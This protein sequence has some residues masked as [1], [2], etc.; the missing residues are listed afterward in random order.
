MRE[1]LLRGY[2]YTEIYF[3]GPLVALLCYSAQIKLITPRNED[4]FLGPESGKESDGGRRLSWPVLLL[5]LAAVTSSSLSALC[6]CHLLALQAEVEE[7]R[8][9]SRRGEQRDVAHREVRGHK[10]TVV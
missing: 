10:R 1:S 6:L 9:P 7:L 8:S 2:R 3:K 5:T 4:R